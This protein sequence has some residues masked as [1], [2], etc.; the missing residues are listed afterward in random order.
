MAQKWGKSI[1]VTFLN[2]ASWN[3]QVT[4]DKARNVCVCV[5]VEYW[6]KTGQDIDV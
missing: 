5:C 6:D 2:S 4:Y 3:F 1:D